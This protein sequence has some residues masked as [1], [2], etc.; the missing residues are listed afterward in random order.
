MSDSERLLYPRREAAFK[1][2][3][4][5]RSL[6]YLIAGKHIRAQRLAK[7]VLIHHRE[8]ERFA[9]TNHTEPFDGG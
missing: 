5:V 8:L 9:R 7:R 4:S 3:I 2:G 1:L 6:D